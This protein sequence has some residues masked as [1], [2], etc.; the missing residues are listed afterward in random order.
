MKV[1]IILGSIRRGRQSEKV[2]SYLAGRLDLR[3]E[4]VHETVDFREPALP[5][6]DERLKYLDSPPEPVVKWGESIRTADRIIV[7]SPEYNGSFAGVLKNALD[8]L[9][10]EYEGKI[11][12]IA[13]VSGGA[14]GGGGCFDALYK[15]FFKMGARPLDVHLKINKVASTFAIKDRMVAASEY[16]DEVESFLEAVLRRDIDE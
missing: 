5:F 1:I 6:M 16:A 11:V 7:V 14:H 4:I 2:A 12:G 13:T 8:Y 10:D 9:N 15:F 3:D